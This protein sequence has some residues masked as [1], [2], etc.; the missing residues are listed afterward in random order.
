MIA[1]L[2]TTLSMVFVVLAC[3]FAA[4]PATAAPA[5]PGGMAECNELDLDDPAAVRARA[6]AEGVTD[7]FAGKV[8]KSEARTSVGGGEGKA[9][10]N[11]GSP[12]DA[13]PNNPNTRTTGWEHTVEV[14]FPFRS[15]LQLADKV[16]VVTGTVADEGLGRLRTGATYLFFA[17]GEEGKN[18]LDAGP[19]SGTRPLPGGLT[20]EIR[21][22]VSSA[23]DEPAGEDVDYT[24]STPDDGAR[25]T[26]SLGRLAAPGAAL[27]LLGVLGLL[28]LARISR[29]RT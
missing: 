23:L 11:N 3:A 10:G 12:T 26:P 17:S 9:S 4:A 7:V 1:V 21:D 16:V 5:P 22:K 13:P 15:A 18:H 8:L 24:L 2:R 20:A 28:L 6:D 19:C 14:D 29:R 27:A 25:S